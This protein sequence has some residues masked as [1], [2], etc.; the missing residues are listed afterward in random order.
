MSEAFTRPGIDPRTWVTMARVDLPGENEGG[1]VVEFDEDDGQLY[2]NV[3]L[4]PSDV[5]CRARLGMQTA[6]AGEA[7]YFPFVGGE[8][9]LVAIPDGDL[10]SSAVIVSRFNNTFDPFPFKSVGGADPKQ[11]AV[12]ML[13][14]RT[15]LTIESGASVQVRSATLGALLV[16]GS[17]GSVTLRDADAN[18]LQLSPDAF[19][20][21]NGAGD[22]VMQIDLNSLRYSLQ[23]G[24]AA[25]TLSGDAAGQFPQSMV[26]VPSSLAVA[27]GGL[28]INTAVEHV[29]TTEAVM[30]V[31]GQLATLLTVPPTAATPIPTAGVLGALLLAQLPLA[32]QAA[33]VAPQ[34]PPIGA[35]LAAAFANPAMAAAKLPELATAPGYQTFPGVGCSG[36]LAGLACGHGIPPRRYGPGPGRP[37]RGGAGAGHG[38]RELPP[39][40]H[41][42]RHLRVQ[43]PA[44]LLAQPGGEHPVP[45]LQAPA[46]LQPL[47]GPQVQPVGPHRGG[48]ELRG[49][50]G[51]HG[52][53]GGRGGGHRLLSRNGPLPG[54]WAGGPGPRPDWA[55]ARDR[56]A[57]WRF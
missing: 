27:A 34:L 55:R 46:A 36:F 45:E 41:G 10:R 47:A 44:V 37:R 6:G 50:P 35:A 1:E 9:V 13:R 43:D 18:V 49:R 8:E 11:N 30:N 29:A 48:G 32:I 28:T 56:L 53:A 31:L 57:P 40:P 12:A 20:F 5:P 38:Q 22:V 19:G 39:E 2:V 26:Q 16:L 14:T 54:L 51:G 17:D 33:S 15:A 52:A 24:Q 3:T 4:K 25:L 42:G 23:V 7:V 21:Q